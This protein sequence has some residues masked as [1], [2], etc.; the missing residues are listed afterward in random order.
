MQIIVTTQTQTL[1]IQDKEAPRF[2]C[3][4]CYFSQKVQDVFSG[5]MLRGSSH[6][7][8]NTTP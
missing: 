7:E 5:F 1:A 3:E 4:G 8:I 2:K 6:I